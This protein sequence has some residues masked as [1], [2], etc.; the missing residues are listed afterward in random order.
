MN[1]IW[2]VVLAALILIG[3]GFYQGGVRN[4]FY[5]LSA[6]IQKSLWGTGEKTVNLF[7]A[8]LKSG[9]LQKELDELRFE[10]QKLLSK[11]AS[12]NTLRE[13]NETLR[14]ALNVGLQNEFKLEFAEIIS[15]D[16]DEDY[17]LIDKGSGSGISENMPVITESKILLGRIGEV[18]KNFSKVMLISNTKSTFEAK[19]QDKE[20]QG[21]IDGKGDLSLSLRLLSQ[22]NDIQDGDL[23]I[24]TA[25]GGIFPKGLLIGEIKKIEKSDV[26]PIQEAI[27]SPFFDLT[28]FRSL[29]IIL[30]F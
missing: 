13:E 2:I 23:I 4:F 16:I 24:T 11:I 3:F 12:L 6:P 1:K 8:I 17:I 19:I 5:S 30:D 28:R 22:E 14:Q 20:I 27:I 9:D 7:K 10:N 25:L 26:K 15:K 29:F 18:S 21:I